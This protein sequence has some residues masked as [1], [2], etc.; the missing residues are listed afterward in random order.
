[1]AIKLAWAVIVCSFDQCKQVTDFNILPFF[2]VCCILN[3]VVDRGSAATS[4]FVL[5]ILVNLQYQLQSSCL[6]SCVFC[7][8]SIKPSPFRGLPLLRALDVKG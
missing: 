3:V 7:S 6:V 2:L 8:I 4:Q 1:M 5:L